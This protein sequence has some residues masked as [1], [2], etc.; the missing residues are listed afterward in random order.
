MAHQVM[1]AYSC[2]FYCVGF[3]LLCTMYVHS[4]DRQTD[5][6][7]DMTKLKGVFRGY[8]TAP[9]LWHT[10]ILGTSYFVA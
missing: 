8:A 5:R 7:T 2:R 1:Y 4:T 3:T 10:D 6:W 9:K